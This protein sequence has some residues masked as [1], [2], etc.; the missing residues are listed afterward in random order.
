MGLVGAELD[1]GYDEAQAARTAV[2]CLDVTTADYHMVELGLQTVAE[3]TGGF[4]TR[5]H[6]F[7]Q[8]AVDR[9]ANALVGHY[10]QFAEK[11]EVEPRHP[12][13]R[14]AACWRRRNGPC[15]PELRD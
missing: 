1:D 8:R 3:D 11:P 7:P 6:L 9:V 15:A 5:T 4:F 12:P 13:H 2:F 10:V 14:G